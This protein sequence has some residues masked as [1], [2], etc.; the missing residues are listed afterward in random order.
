VASLARRLPSLMR[1]S[2]LAPSADSATKAVGERLV[3]GG[4]AR[5]AAF[6]SVAHMCVR[7]CENRCTQH[8]ANRVR[9]HTN[10]HTRAHTHT[11]TRVVEIEQ[12][13]AMAEF[14]CSR[15]FARSLVN[16]FLAV[17][18]EPPVDTPSI[19][20]SDTLCG[21]FLI[22]GLSSISPSSFV[23]LFFYIKG[24]SSTFPSFL[25]CL[26][27]VLARHVV[28]SALETA[29]SAD[30]PDAAAVYALQVPAYPGRSGVKQTTAA[31]EQPATRS[32][33]VCCGFGICRVFHVFSCARLFRPR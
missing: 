4:V 20:W 8:S 11:H 2:L 29:S 1:G 9:V 28:V 24:L 25:P 13:H 23:V 27:Q 32:L 33:R 17:T 14:K 6:R 5:E 22:K 18:L 15:R 3:L 31:G 19:P 26:W 7:T 21:L 16:R 12:M 10:A 30:C